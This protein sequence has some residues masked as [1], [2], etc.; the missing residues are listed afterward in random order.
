MID[1]AEHVISN[2]AA[3]NQILLKNSLVALLIDLLEK[4]SLKISEVF[5]SARTSL[6]YARNAK[7]FDKII[8]NDH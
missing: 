5:F 2:F 6:E 8:L 3:T 7:I 4:E 1:T